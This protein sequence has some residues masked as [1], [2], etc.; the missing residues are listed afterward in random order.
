MKKE[1][2]FLFLVTIVLV[3]GCISKQ[4]PETQSKSFSNDQQI[5]LPPAEKTEIVVSQGNMGMSISPSKGN[6]IKDTVTIKVTKVPEDTGVV[7]FAIQGPGI[8][9]IQKTGPNLGVDTDGSDDWSFTL[10]T[11]QYNNEDYSIISIAYTEWDVKPGTKPRA[12]LGGVQA[13]VKINNEENLPRP[14]L[15]ITA[16]YKV[17]SLPCTGDPTAMLEKAK[18]MHANVIS[19]STLQM[20]A[21]Y[22]EE[23][24]ILWKDPKKVAKSCV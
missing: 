24:G 23:G 6:V 16:P 3:S 14:A 17:I 12:L 19:I 22:D 15:L 18:Q 5:S 1:I 13:Q 21:D 10:N 4:S 11:N 8:E 9:D 7:A 2:L 20:M